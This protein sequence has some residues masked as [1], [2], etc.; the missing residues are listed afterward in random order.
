VRRLL[1]AQPTLLISNG[2]ILHENLASERVTLDDLNVALRRSGVDDVEQVRVAVL[3]ENGG[4]SVIPRA[5]G[6]PGDT[7]ADH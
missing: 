3:E 6:G 5:V 4:I 1:E 7:R 2:R